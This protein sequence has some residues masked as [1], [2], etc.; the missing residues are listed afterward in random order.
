MGKWLFALKMF[1]V[2]AVFFFL[3]FIFVV[4]P[5]SASNSFFK[6][7]FRDSVSIDTSQSFY[8]V[9]RG[10]LRLV[11]DKDSSVNGDSLSFSFHEG[12]FEKVYVFETQLIKDR[13]VFYFDVSQCLGDFETVSVMVNAGNE[14]H[15]F[16]KDYAIERD[17]VLGDNVYYN[18][19]S[20]CERGGDGTK[21]SPMT[22]CS[23]EGLQQI[24]EHLAGHYVMGST[25]DCS[26]HT[27][28]DSF[29]PLGDNFEP[30][31]GSFD[32]QGNI[33][34]GLHIDNAENSYT[35][36]FGVLYNGVIR[37]VGLKNATVNGGVFV[38]GL[39]GRQEGGEISRVFIEQSTVSGRANVGGLVGFSNGE[40]TESYSQAEV[41]SSIF[42]GG[43]VGG[44]E[45]SIKDSYAASVI[46]APY[47]GLIAN[48]LPGSSIVSSYFDNS[49][50]NGASVAGGVALAT[51]DFSNTASFESWDFEE[52]WKLQENS[53]Y[54][55]LRFT[56]KYL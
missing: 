44:C 21:K 49:L 15:Y 30:F 24:S 40:I 36:L 7:P 16:T 27:Q 29:V 55:T 52:D 41:I 39:V 17:G 45:C 54:P 4:N 46:S 56:G 51:E 23:C 28:N 13:S 20:S 35:G 37:N 8:D 18:L 43:L 32:G 2:L 19:C 47:N 25:I 6:N 31:N 26:L 14:K 42:G 33:I 50:L 12:G 9:D 5:L 38:G 53:T 1:S 22:I 3:G 10:R 11:I 48:N 34:Y